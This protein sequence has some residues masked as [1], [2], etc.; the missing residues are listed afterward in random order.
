[1]TK[2][3]KFSRRFQNAVIKYEGR[4]RDETAR[5]PHKAL[6]SKAFI[7]YCTHLMQVVLSSTMSHRKATEIMMFND[8]TYLYPLS[9]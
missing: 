3:T 2:E 6:Q 4:E 8:K 1:M 7:P 9:L 5:L